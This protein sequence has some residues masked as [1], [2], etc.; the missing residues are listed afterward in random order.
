MA[1]EGN[2]NT[3]FGHVSKKT[4]VI[5]GV[6][7]AGVLGI[8]WYRSKQ[9]S[10]SSTDTSST[11][12]SSADIDP[13]T[14]FPYGSPEDIAALQQ[15][16]S[17]S[18]GFGPTFDTTGGGD[19]GAGPGP[20]SFTSNAQ[21]SQYA[22]DY[23]VNSVGLPA[24]DVGNAL[25]KYLTAQPL[26]DAMV[27]IVTQAI[28]FADKPPISGPD[29]FPPSFK[30]EAGPPGPGPGNAKNP[31]SGLEAHARFTQVDLSWKPSDHATS[32]RVRIRT[33]NNKLVQE[34]TTNGTGLTIHN[35][36]RNTS[37]EAN[38]LAQPEAKNATI[39]KRSFKT[40]K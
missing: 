35:L 8:A 31:V 40:K 14:G 34:Q 9:A 7:I 26:T 1:L 38:V 30:H 29:G 28:A 11:D 2:I 33:P 13:A 20:G 25:G 37:Y 15:M 32:Y 4:A 23:L 5:G 17:Y 19:T 18:G 22:E 27:S 24:S 21:W 36:Q 12:T 39:A 16:Q 6:G 10:A 3:P